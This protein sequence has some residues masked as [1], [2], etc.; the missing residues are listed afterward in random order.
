MTRSSVLCVLIA[1][2]AAE[3]LAAQA[4]RDPQRPFEIADNS[5][6]IEEAFNQEAGI[7][8]NIVVFQP[9]RDDEWGVEFTQEWPLGGQRHQ[10]SYTLPVEAER[11]PGAEGY[12]VTRGTIALT[13]RYQLTTEQTAAFASSPRLSVLLP[14]EDVG[15]EWGVQ[16]NLPFSRQFSDV[17]LH[18]NAG[19]TFTRLGAS[20]EARWHAG[21]SLIYRMLPMVHAMLESVYRTEELEGEEGLEDDW[22]ISPGF[23][24]G[25][26]LG[27]HQLVLGAALPIG[28]LE[29]NDTRALITYISYELPFM[30]R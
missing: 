21:A 16:I 1:G 25:I 7:F 26:N 30:R 18:A 10:L 14:R 17:Y 2:L 27:D 12:H 19:S 8:Q 20:A 5:F 22:V 15:D 24:A 13:Y 3:D 4:K 28:L 11:A 6:L 9:P 23:R 29:S